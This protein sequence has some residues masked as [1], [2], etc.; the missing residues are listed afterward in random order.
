MY[1][2]KS[3]F[4]I[5]EST[6]NAMERNI[7]STRSCSLIFEGG[8]NMID[9]SVHLALCV[10]SSIHIIVDGHKAWLAWLAWLATQDSYFTN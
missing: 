4:V 3:E 9:M 2:P 1:V 8:E 5:Q 6:H 7:N 10:F